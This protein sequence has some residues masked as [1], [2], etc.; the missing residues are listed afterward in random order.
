[1]DASRDQTQ[2]GFGLSGVL[3]SR[4][5]V[6]RRSFTRGSHGREGRACLRVTLRDKMYTRSNGHLS[7]K[8]YTKSLV[9]KIVKFACDTREREERAY[10]D[11][12]IQTEKCILA[13]TSI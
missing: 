11:R 12:G 5:C 1:M 2:A 7:L 10:F 13:L 9:K 3:A 4:T 8:K 6:V